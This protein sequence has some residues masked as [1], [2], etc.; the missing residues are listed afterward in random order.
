[1]VYPGASFVGIEIL[2]ERCVEAC[3][4]FNKLGL[5]NCE[6]LNENIVDR[7][8]AM[9]EADLYFIYDFS[10]SDEINFAL[11]QMCKMNRARLYFLVAAVGETVNFLI[12]RSG[13][14][15]HGKWKLID[16]RNGIRIFCVT[17]SSFG[18]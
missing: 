6:M 4:V 14:G 10:H 5:S 1:M 3:R 17:R 11:N 9:P 8:F 18:E 12:G 15:F 13:A 16:S 2:K 7:D